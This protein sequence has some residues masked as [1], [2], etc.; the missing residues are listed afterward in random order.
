MNMIVQLSLMLQEDEY[1][2][3]STAFN[4]TAASTQQREKQL[5]DFKRETAG[6]SRGRYLHHTRKPTCA[7]HLKL[8]TSTAFGRVS[9]RKLGLRLKDKPCDDGGEGRSLRRLGAA[10]KQGDQYLG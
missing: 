8:A 5:S 2:N 6:R 1:A 9:E 3:F 10:L 7:L 4:P